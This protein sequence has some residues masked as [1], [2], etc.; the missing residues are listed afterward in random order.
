ML[1]EEQYELVI[2]DEK[3]K[4]INLN[5]N[6]IKKELEK[7]YAEYRQREGKI[8][9]DKAGW[10][11]P[12]D[13]EE[14]IIKKVLAF[15]PAFDADYQRVFDRFKNDYIGLRK[16]LHT[17]D[18]RWK[19]ATSGAIPSGF[20]QKQ[21]ANITLIT[22]LNNM[23]ESGVKI[24]VHYNEQGFPV[25]PY[26]LVNKFLAM[27]ILEQMTKSGK[28]NPKLKSQIENIIFDDIARKQIGKEINEYIQRTRNV[29]ELPKETIQKKQEH[30]TERQVPEK[31]Q[32]P[33][34]I[35]TTEE[36]PATDK[37][38]R[39]DMIRRMLKK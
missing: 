15:T 12:K 17:I 35:N 38:D 27:N 39:L 6:F 10:Y 7:Q 3:L 18:A 22:L 32:N 26:H 21:P 8:P 1:L 30:E 36:E 29:T 13:E 16:A 20:M 25:Y 9:Q 11:M 14:L 34:E 4:K 2:L 37:E 19:S 24:P 28:I 33:T 23:L 5:P 31:H